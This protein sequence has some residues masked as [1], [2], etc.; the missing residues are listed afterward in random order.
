MKEFVVLGGVV[1]ILFR[2]VIVVS[3]KIVPVEFSEPVAALLLNK[4][5]KRDI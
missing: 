5:R 2:Y 1:S 4:K 3:V